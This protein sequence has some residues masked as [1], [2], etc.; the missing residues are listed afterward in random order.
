MESRKPITEYLVLGVFTVASLGLAACLEVRNDAEVDAG[1]EGCGMCHS[2]EGTGET[3]VAHTGMEGLFGGG[4]ACEDCHLVPDDWF[5]PGHING[6]VEVVFAEGSLAKAGGSQPEWDGN[7][8]T[9]VYCHGATL[10]G[11]TYTDP[12]WDDPNLPDGVG[13]GDCHGVPPLQPHPAS[14]ACS[15]CHEAAY[16]DGVLDKSVH[17]NGVVDFEETGD[18]GV[19]Q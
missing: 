7:R 15:Q 17:I 18:G 9:N 4:Y 5:V 1:D 11:G 12:V 16:T 19:E 6:T 2:A 14:G 3:H 13:C 10:G 8:C